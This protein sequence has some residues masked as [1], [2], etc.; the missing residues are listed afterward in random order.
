MQKCTT[1]CRSLDGDGDSK[2]SDYKKGAML[3]LVL[4]RMALV[5]TTSDTFAPQ[6]EVCAFTGGKTTSNYDF[7]AHVM[8]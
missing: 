5:S 7:F 4:V 2:K 8:L 6:T 3:R 1:A